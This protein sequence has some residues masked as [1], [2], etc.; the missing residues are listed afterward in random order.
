MRWRQNLR[1]SA[2]SLWRSRL[3]T[4]LSVSGMAIGIAA[5]SVLMGFGAGA[6]RAFRQTLEKMGRN[7]MTVNAART[8]PDALRGRS[9]LHE[10]L[11]MSDYRAISQV[12]GVARAA[13]VADGSFRLRYQSR[14][15]ETTVIGTTPSFLPAGNLSLTAGRFIDREDV[16]GGARVAV[17]GAHIV[18]ELFFGEWPLGDSLLVAGSPFTIIGVLET[19]GFSPE[20]S[21]EDDRIIIPVTTAQR[22]LLNVDYLDR[23]FVQAASESV[24][25]ELEDRVA[26]LL[27]ARHR[28]DQPGSSDDFEIRD[29]ARLLKA[30]RETG[31]AFSNLILGLAALALFLGGVG[32][33]AV[34]LLSVRER[35]GEIG[36]RMAVGALPGDILLQ[37]LSESVMVAVLGGVIGL[38]LGASGILFGGAFVGWAVALTWRT[39]VYPFVISLLIAVIFG[40]WPAVSA[41]GLDPIVALGSK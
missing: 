17:I 14:T 12:N 30:Q 25:P 31:S 4:L 26:G 16:A 34:S 33:L 40:A 28:I 3:R 21:D 22:R 18:R 38:V 13:P 2:R 41:A 6:E 37:F 7:L 35:Y 32:I 24:M 27:R 8:E 5:V 23:I 20:G 9:R 11:Q 36:L 39:I 15:L 19:R 1:L 29:Q 10:T